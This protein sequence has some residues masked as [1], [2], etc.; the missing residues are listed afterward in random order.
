MQDK[1]REDHADR[2][3][4]DFADALSEL[5][6]KR[7][8]QFAVGPETF[9]ALM[10]EFYGFKITRRNLQLYHSPFLHRMLPPPVHMDGHRSWYLHPEHTE[11]LAVIVHLNAK[12]FMPLKKIRLLLRGY[13]ERYYGVLLKDVLT[14]RDLDEIVDHFGRGFEIKDFL[15]HKINRVLR[16]LDDES[17][18]PESMHDQAT[19]DKV[20]LKK[21]A[22]Y[23]HWLH[24]DKSHRAEV[25][26]DYMEQPKGH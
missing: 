1:R 23:E 5:R 9:L 15:F 6:F 7:H 4:L 18:E 2:P 26:L 17:D 10:K 16:A 24:S 19:R 3:K 8:S 21:A 25:L 11:R 14:V 13:P 22:E 12:H 20:L